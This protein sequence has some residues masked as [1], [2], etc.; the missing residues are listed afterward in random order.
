MG[1]PNQKYQPKGKS[2]LTPHIKKTDGESAV[3]EHRACPIA[4]GKQNLPWA[5]KYTKLIAR[6]DM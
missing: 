3:L 5:T 6:L 4:R 2:F 1:I